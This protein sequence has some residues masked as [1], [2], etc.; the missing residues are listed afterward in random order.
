MT[1][2][3]LAGTVVAAL[4]LSRAASSEDTAEPAIPGRASVGALQGTYE[5]WSEAYRATNPPGPV[6]A[7]A[8][9]RGLSTEFS[10][11]R[12]I[13]QIDLAKQTI[14]VRIANLDPQITDVWLVDNQPGEGRSVVPEPGDI[15]VKVGSLKFE[16]G[17]AWLDAKVEQLSKM[18]VDMVV[19]AR[20]DQDPGQKGVLFGTTSLFQRIFHYP[21]SQPSAKPSQEASLGTKLLGRLVP[22]AHAQGLTPPG[23]FHGLDSN[24]INKGRNI[25]QNEKFKGNGRTCA[26]C[27]RE[28]DNFALGIRLIASLPANDPLF[29]VEQP[30][31]FDGT[32]NALYREFRFEKPALMRH[33]GLILE[34]QNGFLNPEGGFTDQVQ[35]RAPNHLLSLRTTLAPPPAFSDDGTL[36]VDPADLVFAQRTGWGGDG[37]P[38]GFRADFFASNHRNLTGSLRDFAVGAVIQHFTRTLQR[39]AS[40][41]DFRFPTEEELDALEA[42]QLSLGRQ[43]DHEDLNT[44][45]L[46]DPVAERGRLNFMG[47][48][49]HDT[50]PDDGRPPLNCNSCHFNGGAKTNPTFPFPPAI[51]PNH[52]LA[53]LAAHGGSIP[54][55]NRSFGPA[56]ERLA[57]QAGDIIVQSIDD[58]SIAGNC[59]S[60]NLGAIPLLPTDVPGVPS[61]GCSAKPFD[62]GFDFAFDDPFRNR[63]IVR[64]RFNAQPV[65]EAMDTPPFFHGHQIDTVEGSVLFFAAN[66]LL[67]NGEFLPAIV[68]LNGAQVINVARFLRVMGADFN[69][70]SAITLLDKARLFPS[71]QTSARQTNVSLAKKE[72]ED[73]LDLIRPVNLHITDAEPL[74]KEALQIVSC[75]SAVYTSSLVA[76][77][78]L[79]RRAQDAMIA[80]SQVPPPPPPPHGFDPCTCKPGKCADC[81]SRI[82]AC[83]NMPGCMDIVRCT[84]DNA[85]AF[86]HESC[87]GGKSCFTVTG[88]DQSS[89]AGQTA[90]GVV[91][92]FGGC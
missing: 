17:Y 4:V 41:H 50:T 67:R 83:Q 15:M 71:H 48:N 28:E 29:I 82:T 65:I 85:C 35:M 44:I 32:P 84:Y 70:K 73:A 1:A 25:F 13:A 69:A 31:R 40:N 8:Y 14:S 64:D 10:D 55:H 45:Q 76:A 78:G 57:D 80:R 63:R 51:T 5:R 20:S 39:S 3:L 38:T 68:P 59:F 58:P 42:F 92:C 81:T 72:I 24:L 36:P 86:P 74:F 56:V 12:G 21:E 61:P 2:V 88:H 33:L 49:V 91:S 9:N 60:Q 46:F 66:R 54:S 43:T 11:G 16:K 26:S 77:I 53:D 89:P 47:F 27:H 22:E 23:Y 30:I 52:D 34:N 18:V 87:V 62:D 37:S 90:N 6:V 79:L 19:V 75:A 7:L